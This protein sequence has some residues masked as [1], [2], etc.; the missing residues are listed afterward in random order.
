MTPSMTPSERRHLTAVASMWR[1]EATRWRRQAQYWK[2]RCFAA[3]A[4]RKTTLLSLQASL[5]A[6]IAAASKSRTS[7]ATLH[8]ALASS[9]SADPC[10]RLQSWLTRITS[11]TYKERKM[12][13]AVLPASSSWHVHQHAVLLNAVALITRIRAT[14][15]IPLTTMTLSMLLYLYRV[16]DVVWDLMCSLKLVLSRKATLKHVLDAIATPW[17][18]PPHSHGDIVLAG[19]DNCDLYMAIKFLRRDRSAQMLHCITWWHMPL[20]AEHWA[21][22]ATQPLPSD[23]WA[24]RR[25]ASSGLLLARFESHHVVLTTLWTEAMHIVA[26]GGTLLQRKRKG[27]SASPADYVINPPMMHLTTQS[28]GNVEKILATV[29]ERLCAQLGWRKVVLVGDQQTFSH[30]WNLKVRRPQ[31]LSWLLPFPGEWHFVMHICMAIFSTWWDGLLGPLADCCGRKGLEKHMKP[32]KWPMFDEFLKV[33]A[34][35]LSEWLVELGG[36][37]LPDDPLELLQAVQSNKAAHTCVAFLFYIGHFY[38]GLRD[39]IR[40]KHVAVMDW[41][42]DWAATI[43]HQAH[44]TKYLQLAV[45]TKHILKHCHPSLAIVLTQYR[46]VQLHPRSVANVELDLVCEQVWRPP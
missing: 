39:A 44:K 30:M 41:A 4:E 38:V 36:D 7:V 32:A 43:F 21:S 12:A 29:H 1:K 46:T 19:A 34:I 17:P 13:E 28:A 2:S 33:V 8:S 6:E 10:P 24:E 22:V 23:V 16:P 37:E 9:T 14:H 20:A 35:A 15:A 5:S 26:S 27:Q 11:N 18:I 40:S 42:W 25:P 31:E 45:T 3:V